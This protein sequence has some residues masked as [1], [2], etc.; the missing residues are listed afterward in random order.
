RLPRVLSEERPVVH[1]PRDPDAHKLQQ[2]TVHAIHRRTPTREIAV[3]PKG[4]ADG[5]ETAPVHAE[6]ELMHSHGFRERIHEVPLPLGSP[7]RLSQAKT[8]SGAVA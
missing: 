5:A 1:P 2:C 6:F 4:I 7:V 3:T 8:K